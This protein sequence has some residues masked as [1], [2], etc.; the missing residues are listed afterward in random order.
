MHNALLATLTTTSILQLISV[1][2]LQASSTTNRVALIPA[3][4]A[5]TPILALAHASHVTLYAPHAQAP[6]RTTASHARQATT[7]CL[8][9]VLVCVKEAISHR[10]AQLHAHTHALQSP[11]L[12]L[13]ATRVYPA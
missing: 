3:L 2:A 1:G 7:S 9:S 11:I 12:M 10:K 5:H 6:I 4:Q 13:G 8:P